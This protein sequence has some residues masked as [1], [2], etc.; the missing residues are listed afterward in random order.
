MILIPV[1]KQSQDTPHVVLDIRVIEIHRPACLGRREAAQHKQLRR[2][3]QK[4][5]Q[6]VQLR[7]HALR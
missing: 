7:H 1:K 2:R 5:A 4:E 3:G 6:R